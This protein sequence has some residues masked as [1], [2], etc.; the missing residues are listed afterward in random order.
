MGQTHF[1]PASLVIFLTDKKAYPPETFIFILRIR[2]E[3]RNEVA[4][5]LLEADTEIVNP[6]IIYLK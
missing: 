3:V 6:R 5:Q 4:Y 1:V 2:T